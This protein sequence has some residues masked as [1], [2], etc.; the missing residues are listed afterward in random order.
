MA[1][2]DKVWCGVDIGSTKLKVLLLA[3]DGQVLW[4]ENRP[5]PRTSDGVGACASAETILAAIEAM[6]LA[7]HAGAGLTQP[8]TA[9]AVGG[10]GEDGVPID[11]AAQP[12][13]VAI[14]WFDR[15]AEAVAR[16]AATDPI[17][18]QSA[19]PVDLDYSRTA[20][21]W[22][23]LRSE[24]PEVID[25]AASWVALTD[26]PAVRWSGRP[27]MSQSLAARTAC[28]DI[29]RERWLERH[30]VASGAPPLPPVVAGGTI[31]GGVNAPALAAAD[32]VDRHTVVVAGGHDHPMAALAV[33]RALPDAII[34]SMGTA[35]LLYGEMP[36]SQP[37]PRHS[38]F[39]YSRP[40]L[41]SGIACLGVMELSRVLEPLLTQNDGAGASFRDVMNGA[42][43]PGIPRQGPALRD[44]LEDCADRTRKR[45]AALAALGA[46]TGPLFATGGWARS[47]SLLRLRASIFERPI[48][49]VEELELSAYGAALVAAIG[50]GANPTQSLTWREIAPDLDWA[51]AYA[52]GR[53]IDRRRTII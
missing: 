50:S 34:D 7:A 4:R 5:T 28:Y 39:A 2:P 33:R 12:L 47:P 11:E 14:P 45:L 15:R 9:I 27:F 1:T 19:V 51:A 44:V 32:A 16:D 26:Y 31:L 36:E 13:D 10:V 6:I 21:K 40:I 25:R 3:E 22:A 20:A 48:F 38:S 52:T 49:A 8:L 43:V 53:A 18:Q 35:E 37:T 46:P 23:W 17:W 42:D 30:L 29:V 24:R 41:G